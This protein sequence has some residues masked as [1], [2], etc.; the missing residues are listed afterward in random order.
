M[1]AKKGCASK[2]RVFGPTAGMAWLFA[3]NVS[4]AGYPMLTIANANLLLAYADPV[5]VERYVPDML[6]GRVFGTMC[7]SEPQAGSSLAD[8]TTRALPQADGTYRL[9]GNKMW[10]SG[11]EHE[12]ADNI[13]HLVLARLRG[14]A[15]SAVPETTPSALVE[16]KA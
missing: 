1:S 7:L 15:T 2:K 11:G 4:T 12:L 5:L 16:A 10:I 13:I 8:V 9:H 6:A 14:N 3:A